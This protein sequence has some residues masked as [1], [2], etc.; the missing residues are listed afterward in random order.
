MKAMAR[1]GP[2]SEDFLLECLGR[3]AHAE[4]LVVLAVVLPAIGK[5]RHD[6]AHV[7]HQDRAEHVDVGLPAADRQRAQR[8]AVIGE[9][10]RDE[11]VARRLAAFDLDL[12]GE[13]EGGFVGLRAA[14]AEIGTRQRRPG[15]S[16]TAFR[17]APRP[18]DW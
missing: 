16:A 14:G 6:L 5:A 12:A 18:G 7:G 9:L 10:A 1:C 13:L 15:L 17:P 2:R 11:M 3:G 8:I 4:L